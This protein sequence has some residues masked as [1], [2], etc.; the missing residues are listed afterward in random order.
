MGFPKVVRVPL[1]R[2]NYAAVSVGMATARQP[3]IMAAS[4]IAQATVIPQRAAFVAVPESRSSESELFHLELL[5]VRLE[6]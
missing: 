1:L 4:V 5:A 3:T 2:K 6:S